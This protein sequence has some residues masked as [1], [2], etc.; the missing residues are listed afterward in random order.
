LN[1]RNNLYFQTSLIHSLI[2]RKQT[3]QE[4]GH[5]ESLEHVTKRQKN[6][7]YN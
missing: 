2:Y 7:V 5:P 6:S 4:Q 1:T 3:K